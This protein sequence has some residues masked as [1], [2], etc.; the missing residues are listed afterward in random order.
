MAIPFISWHFSANYPVFCQGNTTLQLQSNNWH[1]FSPKHRKG[2]WK[3]HSL[4]LYREM[5]KM[6][7]CTARPRGHGRETPDPWKERQLAGK[8]HCLY[9]WSDSKF[10]RATHWDSDAGYR[11][12]FVQQQYLQMQIQ[13]HSSPG[14]PRS[15]ESTVF[16]CHYDIS[17]QLTS[18]QK[19]KTPNS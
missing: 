17:I 16:T 9:T 4:W 18:T 7:R 10:W 14:L 12:C 2:G 3:C 5:S 15:S 13:Y 6:S 19:G 1:H 11:L 8:R